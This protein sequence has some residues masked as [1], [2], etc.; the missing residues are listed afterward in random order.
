MADF[1]GINNL[2][3]GTVRAVD[4]A[5]RRLRVTTPLGELSALLDERLRI[6]D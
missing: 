1:I 3:D 2:I 4:A 6:G 5:Q